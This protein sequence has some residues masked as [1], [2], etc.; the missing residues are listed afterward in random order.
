MLRHTFGRLVIALGLL[1]GLAAPAGLAPVLA[2]TACGG[3]NCVYLPLVQRSLDG[4]TG[5][6]YI[7]GLARQWDLDNPV[8]PAD[9]HADKNIQLRGYTDVTGQN[10]S[11]NFTPGYIS[12]GMDDNRGPQL[13]YLYDPN[14]PFAP[15]SST[16]RFY[17]VNGWN[18][19]TSPTPGTPG[20][21]LTGSWPI[22]G[23]G[24]PVTAGQLIYLPRTGLSNPIA[25]GYH[26]LV[27]YMDG[28]GLAVKYTGED[29]TQ[30]NGYTLHIRNLV[31]DPTLLARYNSDNASN[32][33]RY[34]FNGGQF[35]NYY[36]NLPF[37]SAGQ[38]IGRAAGNTLIVAVV[39]TG[40]FMDPRSCHEW[41]IGLTGGAGRTCPFHT[42]PG[43]H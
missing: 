27:M 6:T 25:P 23:L 20:A 2:A 33:P 18:W 32:G 8:R 43:I 21:P 12:Y 41:W 37:L 11:K 38:P 35:G 30:P 13:G 15:L 29:S 40:S 1:F 3:A 19:G 4:T 26:A 36:Y 24:L 7:S 14:T 28:N 39:D 10:V 42:D 16:L 17:Q 9:L 5:S 22:T 31:P 34:V